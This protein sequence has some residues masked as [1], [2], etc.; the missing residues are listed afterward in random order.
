VPFLKALIKQG[1][2]LK[3]KKIKQQQIAH[4]SWFVAATRKGSTVAAVCC[5]T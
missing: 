1:M 5:E 4:L 3:V 2:Y